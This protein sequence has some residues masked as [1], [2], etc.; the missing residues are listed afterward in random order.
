MTSIN[1][2]CP[3]CGREVTDYIGQMSFQ[4]LYICPYCGYD[5][6]VDLE[7]NDILED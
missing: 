2:T 3:S 4:L 1:E 5:W 6:M 7:H